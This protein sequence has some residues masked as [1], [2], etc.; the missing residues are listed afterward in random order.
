MIKSWLVASAMGLVLM[1]P[2]SAWADL[3]LGVFPRRPA[4]QTVPAFTPLAE[5]LSAELGEKVTLVVAKDFDAFWQNVTNKKYDIVHLNQYQYLKSKSFGYKVF[6]ANE[7]QQQK[8]LAGV[9][10]VR[11][12]S[13]ISK[14]ADLKG[15]T[16]MFGG[17][18][19]AMAAYVAPT[20][21]LK[22]HGL[23]EGKDY[24]A[25]FAPNPPAAAI[26]VFNKA[27]D[28]GGVGDAILEQKAVTTAINLAEIILLEKSDA[29]AQLPWAVKAD[30][31]EAKA[32]KIQQV[33]ID[34]QSSEGGK[35]ILKAAMVDS[36]FK[37]SDADYTKAKQIIES[38]TGEKL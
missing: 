9:L 21:I 7:E 32:A 25:R 30:L 27:A 16:I 38:V 37:V 19:K 18:H 5:K 29:F 17:D 11:K 20:A 2:I 15:K 34:L 4:N 36:F 23:I 22:K 12:D 14:V 33:M 24:Q 31:A 35:A 28:A 13:G 8:E 1:G 26:A 10:L 3:T 6:V